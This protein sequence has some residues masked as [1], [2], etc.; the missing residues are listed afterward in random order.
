MNIKK[1][2]IFS[3]IFI[4]ATTSLWAQPAADKQINPYHQRYADSLKNMN[5][6]HIFPILGKKAYKKGFD[7]PLPYGVTPT[8][9]YM[10]Q[11][12]DITSTT[13]GFNDKEPIDLNNVIQ[14]GDVINT[15]NI[16]TVRPDLWVLPFLDL[17]AVL[18]YG[19]SEIVVPIDRI[20]NQDLAFKTTQNF[21]V[22]SFGL[23]A[24]AAGGLGPVFVVFDYN[25]NWAQVE[26]VERPVMAQNIDMRIGHSFINPKRPDRNI[27]IW[28]GTFYQSI[29][30][31]TKGDIKM[32]DVLTPD[33]AQ[34]LKDKLTNRIEND[35]T[36]GPL[37]K[38]LFEEVI[39][40]G[41]DKLG[42]S[43]VHY[44]L[45]KAIAGPWNL[46]FGAQYQHNKHWQTRVELGA[47]GERSQFMLSLS[48]RFL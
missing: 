11:G 7:I 3:G 1:T 19:R 17:Y 44:E 36:I 16:M 35:P 46:I 30:S 43:T 14:Y 31:Q 33:D 21:G 15:T 48:Y 39:N 10:K 4:I 32:S 24:T 45:N 23:G 47:F 34:N 6:D 2:W 13:I 9:F 28:V 42:T 26:V 40:E 12:I 41:V 22:E 20:G 38:K 5:Y 8:Y 37:E 18:G 25:L 29:K 27:T